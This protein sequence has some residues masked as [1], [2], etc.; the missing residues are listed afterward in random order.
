MPAFFS[1]YKGHLRIIQ[2]L[3]GIREKE[4]KGLTFFAKIGNRPNEPA[5]KGVGMKKKVMVAFVILMITLF[6]FSG[7]CIAGK[8]DKKKS[9]SESDD[10]LKGRIGIG[11]SLGGTSGTGGGGFSGALGLTYYWIKYVSTTAT[12]GYGFAPYSLTNAKGE[13]EDV[14]VNFVPADLSLHIHPLPLSTFSPYFGPGAGATYVWY[15]LDNKQE[16]EM[17]YSAFGD[18]GITYWVAKN[19]GLNLGARYTVPYY[20]NEWKTDEGQLSYGLSGSIVF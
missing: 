7:V 5:K 19:F 3:E 10:P 12:L 8:K 13:L 6:V 2:N 9:K 16:S 11:I 14:K 1:V 17:W 18:V 15:D 20:E 4:R